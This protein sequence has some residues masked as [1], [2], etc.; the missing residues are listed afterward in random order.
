M[1]QPVFSSTKMKQEARSRSKKKTR[2]RRPVVRCGGSSKNVEQ[3]IGATA[4]IS[5]A[6]FL[7]PACRQH[8]KPIHLRW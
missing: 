5:A 6:Q 4:L 1:K 3:K 8:S 2:A 7:L